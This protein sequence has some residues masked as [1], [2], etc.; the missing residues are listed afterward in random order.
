MAEI[1]ISYGRED[2]V[3]AEALAEALTSLGWEVWWDDS[4]RA[5]SPFDQVIDEQLDVAACV[6][7]IWSTASVTSSWVRAEASAADEQ[8]KLLPVTFERD[9]RLP[10]RFRQL[11]VAHLTSTNLWEPTGEAV[12]LL[13]D[14]ATLTGKQPQGVDQNLVDRRRRGRSSGARLVTAGDWRITLR[15][16]GVKSQYDLN[17]RPNGTVSGSGKLGFS[18]RADLSGR[19]LFDPTEHVLHLELSGG[20]Q[21]GTKALPVKI[22]RWET[23]EAAEVKFVHRNARLERVES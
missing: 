22:V 23:A 17:L 16:F 5:G 4:I 6:I 2:V 12:A 9:L 13:A 19:W 20:N 11:N 15:F 1:F 3:Q 10:V 18:F 8:G 21:E 14:I 7:V